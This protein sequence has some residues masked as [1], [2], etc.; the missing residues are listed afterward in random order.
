LHHI[1]K[2]KQLKLISYLDRENKEEEETV[3]DIEFDSIGK[4]INCCEELKVVE[5]EIKETKTVC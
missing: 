3:I 4:R 1:G 5:R 2:T